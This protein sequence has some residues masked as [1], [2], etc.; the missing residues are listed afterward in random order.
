MTFLVAGR[1]FANGS[2]KIR[3]VGNAGPMI[4]RAA[5]VA[6]TWARLH[7]ARIMDGWGR[8][9]VDLLR[10]DI[11]YFLDFSP[12]W[13]RKDG[14]SVRIRVVMTSRSHKN[15]REPNQSFIAMWQAGLAIACSMAQMATGCALDHCVGL[16]GEI[17]LQGVIRKV[18]GIPGKVV[19]AVKES[20]RKVVVPEENEEEAITILS[21]LSSSHHMDIEG[22]K[23]VSTVLPMVLKRQG[24]WCLYLAASSS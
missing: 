23:H 8:Q 17:T 6:A 21:G 3:C 18:D 15:L 10:Q 4:Q 24:R 12:S 19:A 20:L 13:L 22:L 11:D 16:T 2:G 7:Q 1:A 5:L 9:G 14:L